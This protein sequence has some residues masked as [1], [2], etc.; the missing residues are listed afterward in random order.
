MFIVLMNPKINQ[1]NKFIR[2]IEIKK[3]KVYN[4]L[5]RDEIFEIITEDN[6]IPITRILSDEDYKKDL[7]KK[8]RILSWIHMKQQK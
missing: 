2:I 3:K 4:K 6:C 5:V 8:N 1:C 7:E